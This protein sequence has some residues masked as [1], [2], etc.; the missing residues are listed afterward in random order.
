MVRALYGS[1]N[2]DLMQRESMGAITDDAKSLF[3]SD[4]VTRVMS[5]CVP[6]PDI[7]D[8]V[9]IAVD[10]NGGG[11]SQMAIVSIVFHGENVHIVGMDTAPTTRLFF[12]LIGR[13]PL[14]TVF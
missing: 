1:G 10:P 8:Y 9:F 12:F 5:T 13:L 6:L 14:S 2:K 7:A 3:K 4:D 11:A